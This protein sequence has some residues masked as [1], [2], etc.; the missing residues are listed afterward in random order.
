MYER[1][2]LGLSSN[3]IGVPYRL[4]AMRGSP[5]NFVC[6]NPRLIH[7]STERVLLD[8]GCLSF[9]GMIVKIKRPSEIRV[10]FQLPNGD[11]QT[12]KFTGITARVVQHEIDHLDGI[13]YFNR[14][15]RYHREQALRRWRNI[16]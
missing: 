3:Q 5:Q 14:A 2:G 8:E 10:R 16:S 11:T 12:H 7:T 15:S 9:P 13:L 4:F 6:I 1:N